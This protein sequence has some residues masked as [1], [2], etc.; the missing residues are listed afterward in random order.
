MEVQQMQRKVKIKL[1][2][3][4]LLTGF[5]IVHARSAKEDKLLTFF[6]RLTAPIPRIAP[7]QNYSFPTN[8]AYLSILKLVMRCMTVRVLVKGLRTA[9]MM[10]EAT[11]PY[12]SKANIIAIQ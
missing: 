10:E 6:Y 9:K 4:L 7:I 1:A 12:R 2:A 3:P 8:H 5:R 11:T